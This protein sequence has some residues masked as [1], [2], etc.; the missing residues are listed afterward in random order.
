MLSASVFALPVST[1]HV[2]VGSLFGIALTTGE[3]NHRTMIGILWSWLITVPVAAF[4]AASIY[5]LAK[6]FFT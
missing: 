2:S 6:A 1:T 3:A 5:L 4:L